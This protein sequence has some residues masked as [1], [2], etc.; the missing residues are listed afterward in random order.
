[1]KMIIT[2]IYKIDNDYKYIENFKKNLRHN[3][4]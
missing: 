3:N 1:M 4:N 2:D